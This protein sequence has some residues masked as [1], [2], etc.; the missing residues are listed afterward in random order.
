[1]VKQS[2]SSQRISQFERINK[3]P[4]DFAVKSIRF[5][6]KIPKLNDEPLYD[7]TDENI[8]KLKELLGV[9]FVSFDGVEKYLTLEE[10]AAAIFCMT[11]RGHKFGNGNKRTAVVLLLG[12][13]FVNDKWVTFSWAELYELAMEVA[14]GTSVHFEAQIQEVAQILSKK[15]IALVEVKE[16]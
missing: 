8:G 9:P 2:E 4:L 14:K 3:I 16:Q 1:M 5:I 11:I 10:K 12:L 13:L 7:L 15:V 6:N